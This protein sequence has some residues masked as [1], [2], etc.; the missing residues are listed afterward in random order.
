VIAWVPFD[1]TAHS[2]STYLAF[3]G[4]RI[5]FG[6]PYEHAVVVVGVNGDQ[7]LMNNPWTGQEWISKAT[8]EAAY[9]M[10][11]QMAVVIS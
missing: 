1:W 10:F 8:F 2:T 9:S 3:D 5:R 6:A 4:R 7:L 11:N